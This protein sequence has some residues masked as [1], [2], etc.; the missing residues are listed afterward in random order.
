MQRA[1]KLL[2]Q[3]LAAFFPPSAL[4]SESRAH[5]SAYASGV[6]ALKI[7]WNSCEHNMSGLLMTLDNVVC[8]TL[9]SFLSDHIEEAKRR[10][11]KYEAS[12]ADLTAMHARLQRGAATADSGKV[13]SELAVFQHNMQ[14]ST[15]ELITKLFEVQERKHILSLDTVS[16]VSLAH[17][18]YFHQGYQIMSGV[19]TH[20]NVLST[21][22]Q[23]RL[24]E[25]DTQK[26]RFT[27]LGQD[28][29]DHLAHLNRTRSQ[30]AKTI[31][32]KSGW[33]YK[34]SP[35][36]VGDWQRRW[37]I[38]QDGKLFYFRKERDTQ[39]AGTIPLLL[40]TVRENPTA[41]ADRWWCFEL[42]CVS[43]NRSYFLQAENQHDYS[44]WVSCVR[45]Q[46]ESLLNQGHATKSMEDIRGVSG[47]FS[48]TSRFSENSRFSDSSRPS[49]TAS[50]DFAPDAP[51][52]LST[53]STHGGEQQGSASAQQPVLKIL[54][55]KSLYNNECADCSAASP[56]W[57]V[58]NAG[59]LVCIECSGIHRS[60]GVH[61]SKVRSLRLDSLRTEQLAILKEVGNET[62]LT[63]NRTTSHSKR[64]WK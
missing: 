38:V 62:R 48:D 14:S 20:I 10:Q 5:A 52:R 64:S 44:I 27:K 60:L 54:Q 30:H 41:A 50:L 31:Q 49:S 7:A 17:L 21:E 51:P 28:L 4:D 6:G 39:P 37:C 13:K 24:R 9:E 8:N 40:C 36:V 61:I 58:L 43:A 23:H 46:I 56:E 12:V 59:V 57:C 33:L 3:E 63:Q 42:V 34:K 19:E 35:N 2:F 25:L 18:A 29:S 1:S 32:T 15:F 26:K 16:A 45:N 11:R 55:N 47:Q 53:Q 22:T